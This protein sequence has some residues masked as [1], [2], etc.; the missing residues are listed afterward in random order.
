MLRWLGSGK[1]DHIPVD[2]VQ[3]VAPKLVAY[4]ERIGG[5]PAIAEYYKMRGA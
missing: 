1:L 2:L 3:T 5:V 4:I